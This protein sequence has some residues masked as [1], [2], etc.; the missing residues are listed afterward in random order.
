MAWTLHAVLSAKKS[1]VEAVLRDD[2]IS[3]QSHKIRDAASVGGPSGQIYVVVEGNAEAVARAEGMLK[4][5]EEPLP[6]E[7]RTAL[8]RRFKEEEDAASSGMGLF[9]TE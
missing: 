9:F 6:T 3:R 5:L 8:H 1:E 7:E 4:A 2:V